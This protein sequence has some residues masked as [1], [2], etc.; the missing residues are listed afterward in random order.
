MGGWDGVFRGV[1]VEVMVKGGG[2]DGNKVKGE[3]SGD[4]DAM[5]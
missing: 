2:D 3:Y 1:A 4:D 5:R